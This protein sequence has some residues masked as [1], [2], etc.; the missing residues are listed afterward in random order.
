ME[1]FS[2][3]FLNLK[4]SHKDFWRAKL[5]VWI[6]LLCS[7]I[8]FILTFVN[9]FFFKD[10]V[11]AGLNI[12]GTII[13]A[14]IY[15]LFRYTKRL[16]LS[17]WITTSVATLLL[18]TYIYISDGKDYSI[19]WITLVP[20][21][22]F[23][24]LGKKMGVS[25]TLMSFSVGLLY[26]YRQVDSGEEVIYTSAALMNVIDVG[27]SQILLFWF[28]EHSKS[29]AYQQLYTKTQE[30]KHLAEIDKLTNVYNR[31][32]FEAVFDAVATQSVLNNEK[33]SAI[34]LDIDYFKSINDN[35][36]HLTG[37]RVLQA[38]AAELKLLTRTSD[39]II[40]WGGE[41]FVILLEKTPLQIAVSFAERVREHVAC[42]KLCDIDITLSA[43]VGEY[44]LL[45]STDSF[46]ERV[47][48]ALYR[49]KNN[50][51]NCVES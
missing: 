4:P 18:F 37:D 10:W 38:L 24:L 40:R 11:V 35:Y 36:G 29:S 43:G 14:S 42:M 20:T 30:I 46:F 15:L 6:G 3:S 41:E 9:F 31:D 5:I 39:L 22:S 7:S 1:L 25:F 48:K 34:I 19:F 50:G 21:I 16:E 27:V 33:L 49:A 13:F 28:Y 51:R 17:A 23:F 47:D 2:S 12:L 44:D 45:E 8:C 32:K 26:I